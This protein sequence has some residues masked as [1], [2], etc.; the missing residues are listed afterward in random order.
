M[1]LAPP[2]TVNLLVSYA[3][4]DAAAKA[5]LLDRLQ[6]N[7]A[8]L[9][10]VTACLPGAVRAQTWPL[11][12]SLWDDTL[13]PAGVVWDDFIR[14][15]V[16]AATFGLHLLSPSLLTSAYVRDHEIDP[17]VGPG[18]DRTIP[19]L[20]KRL[21]LDGSMDLRGF[22]RRQIVLGPDGRPYDELARPS[23]RDAF[24]QRLAL[25][26]RGRVQAELERGNLT[27]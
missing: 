18:H 8:N 5:D 21:P 6:P 15:H 26:I 1:S 23:E 24:A 9:S 4:A 14:D 20:L 3:H 12:F 27:P 11:T 13:I 16:D 22:Q 2:I 19:V 10:A 17:F 7:L 25:G